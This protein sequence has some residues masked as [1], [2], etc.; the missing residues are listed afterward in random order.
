MEVNS[1]KIEARISNGISYRLFL[2]IFRNFIMCGVLSLFYYLT[3]N[4]SGNYSL[5]DFLSI[6]ALITLVFYVALFLGQVPKFFASAHTEDTRAPRFYASL[7]PVLK[8]LFWVAV[9]ALTFIVS[10]IALYFLANKTF[11]PDF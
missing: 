8:L 1:K 6:Y 2:R 7:H 5:L 11:R 4:H 10:Y 9:F 3:S